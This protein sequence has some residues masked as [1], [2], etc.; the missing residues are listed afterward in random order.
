MQ[1]APQLFSTVV[2]FVLD[3]MTPAPVTAAS[4]QSASLHPAPDRSVG[5]KSD[6][7]SS[8]EIGVGVSSSACS[9]ERMRGSVYVLDLY[10]GVGTTSLLLARAGGCVL[11]VEV[12]ASTV[13]CARENQVRNGVGVRTVDTG[14]SAGWAMFEANTAEAVLARLGKRRS[15]GIE[16][17]CPE[18]LHEVDCILANPP[19]AGLSS[20]VRKALRASAAKRVVYVSCDPA[21]LRRDVEALAPDFELT[22]T[23]AFDMF[24]QTTHVETVVQLSRRVCTMQLSTK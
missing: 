23:K 20:A 2:S 18:C 24:P 14:H 13:D 11:G 6:K 8:R 7:D 10:C 17:N 22:R 21:T 9:S 12:N 15:K 5:S 1:L 4:L 3:G 16:E 19:R